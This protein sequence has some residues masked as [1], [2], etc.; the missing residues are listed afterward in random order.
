MFFRLGS[1]RAGLPNPQPMEK[2]IK[3]TY[4]TL[5]KLIGFVVVIG[6]TASAQAAI[7]WSDDFESSAIKP[8]WRKAFCNSQSI[9]TQNNRS[10]P[11]SRYMQTLRVPNEKGSSQ[12]CRVRAELWKRPIVSAAQYRE[13]WVGIQL[14]VP[15]DWSPRSNWHR[16]VQ[17][18]Q[19]EDSW[20]TSYQ[21][22]FSLSAEKNRWK[23]AIVWDTRRTTPGK[24]EG[25]K[26]YYIPMDKNEWESFVFHWD[27][28][29]SKGEGLF[30][31]WKNGE[32]VVTHRGPNT[33]NDKVGP[34]TF[35][36][37]NYRRESSGKFKSSMQ[38]Y[39]D[40]LKIGDEDSSFSD[41]AP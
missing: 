12:Y 37:G 18:H 23:I 36:I 35:Q 1:K 33:Y 34:R 31:A 26:N 38:V 4:R 7:E 22:S 17:M 29:H 28:S 40:N 39:H 6:L 20:E 10:I 19:S 41:V 30:Q 15:G 9:T 21:P 24:A 8:G 16:V 25:H 3:N 2:I 14:L 5:T 27:W 11:G 13:T 32:P